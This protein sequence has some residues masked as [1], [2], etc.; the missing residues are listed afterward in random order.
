MANAWQCSRTGRNCLQDDRPGS[1][2]I[3]NYWPRQ[4][5]LQCSIEKP[6]ELDGTRQTPIARPDWQEDH[7]LSP[8]LLNR[9][10][11]PREHLHSPG[12]TSTAQ[13]QGPGFSPIAVTSP[14]GVGLD[15]FAN[16]IS[17]PSHDSH[18]QLHQGVTDVSPSS[19]PG[20]AALSHREA[21]LL[22]HF[23]EHLA[24]WLD[25]TDA[26]QQFKI[27]VTTLAKLSPIL[28][29]AVISYAA[30]HVA[31]AD[32]AD[33]AQEKCIRLLI[34]LLSSV[35][36]AD[37]EAILCAIVILRVC[38]QLSGEQSR[39]REKPGYVVEAN[40]CCVVQ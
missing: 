25:C 20:D 14:S 9:S 12:S 3:K 39:D 11:L 6:D 21:F 15:T 40:I 24:R 18:E 35:A 32:T 22:H 13:V 26:S 8:P 1:L 23:T 16:V 34:P 19:V 36:S 27:N 4:N 33:L 7:S 29:H 30:R 10:P 31:D 37:S 28:R 5:R 38:E 17:P 2:T